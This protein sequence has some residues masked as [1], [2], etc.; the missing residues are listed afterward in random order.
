MKLIA[1]AVLFRQL[2]LVPYSLYLAHSALSFFKIA[3][4]M[5]GKIASQLAYP[6]NKSYLPPIVMVV[7]TCQ[8]H[9]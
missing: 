8:C 6:E 1:Q 7:F 4:N 9:V 3:L 2:L 5:L